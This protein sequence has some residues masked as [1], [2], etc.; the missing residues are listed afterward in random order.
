MGV[1][2][3]QSAEQ[4]ALLERWVRAHGTPQSI[5][6]RARVVLMGADGETNSAI[7]RALGISR[8]TVIMWRRRFPEGG[9]QA[10]SE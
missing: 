6:T 8:P 1:A 4:R 9:P 10:L 5:A 3:P 2:P 7:A